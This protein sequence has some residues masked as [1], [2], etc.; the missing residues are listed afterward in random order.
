MN[1][2]N[3]QPETPTKPATE[4]NF[5]PPQPDTEVNPAR[6]DNTEVDLDTQKINTYPQETPPERH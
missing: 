3:P 2:P 5:Q 6:P 4:P 1:N